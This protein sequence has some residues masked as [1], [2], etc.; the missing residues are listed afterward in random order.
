[1]PM[2]DALVAVTLGA[3]RLTVVG[4]SVYR[5]GHALTLDLRRA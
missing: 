1:M 3:L 4:I 2:L 5:G